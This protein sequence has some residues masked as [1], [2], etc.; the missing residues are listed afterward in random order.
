MLLGSVGKIYVMI[1]L[2][3]L[4]NLFAILVGSWAAFAATAATASVSADFTTGAI[5]EYS[6][7]NANQ[8]SNARSFGT[9]GISKIVPDEHYGKRVIDLDD[10]GAAEGCQ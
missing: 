9:L 6:G 1:Y 7:P 2:R 4:K 3:F 10:H 8:N 5:A